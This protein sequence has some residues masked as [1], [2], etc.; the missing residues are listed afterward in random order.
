MGRVSDKMT[1]PACNAHTSGVN[2]ALLGRLEACPSCGLPGTALREIEHARKRHA[3]TELTGQLETATIR[4]AQAEAELKRLR[5]RMRQV[6]Q[7]FADWEKEDP[8]SAPEWDYAE[9]DRQPEP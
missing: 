1:C 3:G 4:Y 8:L 7:V 2:D 5:I 6:R 9:M